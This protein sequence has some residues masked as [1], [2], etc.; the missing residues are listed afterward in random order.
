MVVE[1]RTHELGPLEFDLLTHP[2][3]KY[4]EVDLD[5]DVVCHDHY[6][7]E[8]GKITYDYVEN[9]YRDSESGDVLLA[10]ISQPVVE[11]APEIIAFEMD[12]ADDLSTMLEKAIKSGRQFIVKPDK[13]IDF[14]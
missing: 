2:S 10:P 5:V 3:L 8:T 9:P 1:V 7:P 14:I 12:P 6:D 4:Y 13:S 11:Q